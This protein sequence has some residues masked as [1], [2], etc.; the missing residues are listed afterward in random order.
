MDTTLEYSYTKMSIFIYLS[1]MCNMNIFMLIF[2]LY[3]MFRNPSYLYFNSLLIFYFID[4]CSTYEK[5]LIIKT[6]SLISIYNNYETFNRKIDKLNMIRSTLYTLN[7]NDAKETNYY[8]F[9]INK[10]ENLVRNKLNKIFSKIDIITHNIQNN[11]NVNIIITIIDAYLNMFINKCIDIYKEIYNTLINKFLNVDK[12]KNDINNEIDSNL[13]EIDIL[14]SELD[15][16][17]ND[18]LDEDYKI[19]VQKKKENLE[20]IKNINFKDMMN[21]IMKFKDIKS[22]KIKNS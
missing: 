17:K 7:D 8:L 9:N 3:N 4:I 18:E 11:K 22:E 5:L 16:L 1:Y 21:T 10:I 2:C 19:D 15:E 12:N 14:M 13:K 6:I 20:F